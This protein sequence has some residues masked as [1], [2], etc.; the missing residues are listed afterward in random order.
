MSNTRQLQGRV[1]WRTLQLH[2]EIF[3]VH[4]ATQSEAKVIVTSEDTLRTGRRFL[5]LVYEGCWLA[6]GRIELEG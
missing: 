6:P 1:P 4:A 3:T 5:L 2:I